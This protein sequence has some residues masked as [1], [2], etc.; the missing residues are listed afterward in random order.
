KPGG[1]NELAIR[2]DNPP[3]SSRWYPGAGI[4][5]NVWLVRT[6]HVHVDLWGTQV[7]TPEVS[8]ERATVDFK[9]TVQNDSQT[10]A[11]VSVATEIY[12]V[13]ANGKKTGDALATIA[14]A[15]LQISAG[16]KSVVDGSAAI[17]N[18]KLW[19]PPPTQKPNRYVALTT[20]SQDGKVVDL[21]A[22]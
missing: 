8:K 17:T 10:A 18:P 11:N 14:P 19:G 13:D 15:N 5:R 21:Y 1:K 2:L 20:V 22:T 9:V 3:N 16:G 7:T 12:S 4:Y 6:E